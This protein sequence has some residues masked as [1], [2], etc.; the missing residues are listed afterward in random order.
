[1]LVKV[2][3]NQGFKKIG[4][5]RYVNGK[6]EV[7]VDKGHS[8]MFKE[9]GIT[10]GESYKPS[11]GLKYLEMLMVW[12]CWSSVILLIEEDSD[13]EWLEQVNAMIKKEN[14]ETHRLKA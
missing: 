8:D 5:I 2:R 4:T 11:D 10:K 12:L 13:K 14:T 9:I 1:M 3:R 7:N 6:V